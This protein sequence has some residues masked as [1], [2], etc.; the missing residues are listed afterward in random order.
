LLDF[1]REWKTLIQTKA[2]NTGKLK[3]TTHKSARFGTKLTEQL[4]TLEHER[5]T[6]EKERQQA[7][8][9]FFELDG[10]LELA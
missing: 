8:R 6:K 1:A 7:E 3:T 9:R 5:D 4:R 2:R 10:L